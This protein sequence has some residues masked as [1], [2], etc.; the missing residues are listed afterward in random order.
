MMQSSEMPRP[1]AQSSEML[2]PL[3]RHEVQILRRAAFGL[4]NVASRVTRRRVGRHRA[5][6]PSRASRLARRRSHPRT[7]Q[8]LEAR[9]TIIS[10]HGAAGRSASRSGESGDGEPQIFRNGRRRFSEPAS[11]FASRNSCVPLPG[12]ASRGL[13]EGPTARSPRSRRG[14][15]GGGQP[16]LPLR[17]STKI[18]TWPVTGRLLRRLGW[19]EGQPPAEHPKTNPA[20]ENPPNRCRGEDKTAAA[21]HERQVQ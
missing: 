17:G 16:N 5:T 19:S 2:S 13:W 12:R 1:R 18:P 7:R 8:T 20:P 21:P 15:A 9:W 4:G 10:N 3:T 14:R 6:C 11:R